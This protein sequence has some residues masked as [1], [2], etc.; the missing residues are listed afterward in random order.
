M[1]VS[2]PFKRNRRRLTTYDTGEKHRKEKPQDNDDEAEELREHISHQKDQI[3]D[4]Q[5]RLDECKHTF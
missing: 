4:L 1:S 2:I 5:E 3:D